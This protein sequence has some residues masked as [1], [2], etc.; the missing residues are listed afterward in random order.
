MR[1]CH[2]FYWVHI[3]KLGTLFIVSAPSGGGKTSLVNA[4]L[5]AEPFNVLLVRVVTYTTRLPRPGDINGQDYHFI[6]E[7]EFRSLLEK[8]FFAEWSMA[9]GTYYGTPVSV[10]ED[11]AQGDSRIL[12]LDRAG[13]QRM[14]KAVPEAV[15]IWIT[16]PSLEV[17]RERLQGR[18]TENQG[19]IERRM[20]LAREEMDAEA[21]NP[22]Y[23]HYIFN[24]FFENSLDFLKNIVLISLNL[25]K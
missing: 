6:Q 12:I 2:L 4:L 9:Y 20:A 1:L 11:L 7:D 21:Q 22:L 25:K 18:N 23:S 3:M 10:L 17:L 8:G 19:Q 24:D 15:L 16:P 5:A 13:A 14:L